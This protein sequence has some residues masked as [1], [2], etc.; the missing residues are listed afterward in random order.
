MK[1]E[2]KIWKVGNKVVALMPS[3]SILV[4]EP[5]EY[6]IGRRKDGQ[7][8]FVLASS[9]PGLTGIIEALQEAVEEMKLRKKSDSKS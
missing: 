6:E 7:D 2:K 8:Q 1:H 4:G 3:G 5:G 9:I